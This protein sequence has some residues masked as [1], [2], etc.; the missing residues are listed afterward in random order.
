MSYPALVSLMVGS[1]TVLV[2]GPIFR[3]LDNNSI[4]EPEFAKPPAGRIPSWL[5]LLAGL[6]VAWSTLALRA[7]GPSML[8]ISSAA[9]LAAA[10]FVGIALKWFLGVLGDRRVRFREVELTL[11]LL[12][13][14]LSLLAWKSLAGTPTDF[15]D[16]PLWFLS[17]FGWCAAFCD[18]A[19]ILFPEKETLRRR[20]GGEYHPLGG[21]K[22]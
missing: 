18:L 21:P 9:A 13:A 16:V 12:A 20:E 11:S 22:R 19:S 2:L 5:L 1:I 17:G 6:G 15:A 10:L 7:W 8:Q 14:P 4:R 3:F